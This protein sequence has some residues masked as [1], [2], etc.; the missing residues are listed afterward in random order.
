M[1]DSEDIYNKAIQVS[2]SE[3]ERDEE[4]YPLPEMN[5]RITSI[6]YI[7]SHLNNYLMLPNIFQDNLRIKGKTKYRRFGDVSVSRA[8]WSEHEKERRK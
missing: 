5:P 4:Y 6:S 7:E 3:L 1:R 2:L 8:K